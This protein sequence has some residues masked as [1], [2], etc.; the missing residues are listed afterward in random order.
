MALLSVQE[1]VRSGIAP[2]YVAAAVGGNQFVNNG[3]VFAHVKNGGTGA[4]T[5]TINSIR[6]CNQGFDH[7]ETVSVSAAGE[8]MVGPFELGRFNNPEQLTSLT[9]SGVTTVT[10]GVFSLI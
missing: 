7:D 9:Y 4:I 8:K 1:I 10:I 3:R 5:V 2:T 6:P